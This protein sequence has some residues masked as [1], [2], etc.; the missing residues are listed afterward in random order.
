MTSVQVQAAPVRNTPLAVPSTVLTVLFA[1]SFSHLLNDTVQALLPS[2]YPMLRDSFNLSFA[3]LDYVVNDNLTVCAGDLVLPLG[4]YSERG[5]GW[6]NKDEVRAEE[7]RPP[8]PGGLGQ[9][10]YEPV[11]MAPLGQM[12][13]GGPVSGAGPG[14][15]PLMPNPFAPDA[16]AAK[17]PSGQ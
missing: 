5:A 9:K 3:Q 8:I 11:T 12:G 10:Y 13:V 6:L 2:I 4:T 1:I 15:M 16:G 14:G 7:H 17:S